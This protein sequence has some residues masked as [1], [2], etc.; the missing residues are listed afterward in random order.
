MIAHLSAL[1]IG[2]LNKNIWFELN[3][4]D[5]DVLEKLRSQDN[6]WLQTLS[7]NFDASHVWPLNIQVL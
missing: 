5:R 7:Q 3:S 1:A 2:E 6:R 4:F